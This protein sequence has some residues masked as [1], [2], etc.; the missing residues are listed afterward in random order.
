MD[1]PPHPADVVLDAL[2]HVG[3]AA[4][5]RQLAHLLVQPDLQLAVDLDHE[6]QDLA[7]K[8]WQLILIQH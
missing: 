8:Q 2:D 6:E 1:G 4:A 5:G 7:S 3:A